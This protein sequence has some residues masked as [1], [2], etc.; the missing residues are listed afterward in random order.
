MSARPLFCIAAQNFVGFPFD[1]SRPD[2]HDDIGSL[3]HGDGTLDCITQGNAGDVEDGR[4]PP[5]CRRN[6]SGPLWHG[7]W[8][9][10]A[11]LFKKQCRCTDIVYL[12]VIIN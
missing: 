3:G 4:Y 8:A 7:P 1:L 6:R 12:F 5:G 9:W 11:T 2:A 10:F